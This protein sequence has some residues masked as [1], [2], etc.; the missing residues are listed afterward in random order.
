MNAWSWPALGPSQTD[1]MT[2]RPQA[3]PGLPRRRKGDG[4]PSWPEGR[5]ACRV[6][7]EAVP[8]ESGLS[9]LERG[10]LSPTWHCPLLPRGLWSGQV[11]VTR[12]PSLN[13]G[14]RG[15]H[16]RLSSSFPVLTPHR[17][18]ALSGFTN[19]DTESL[20][21][22][23]LLFAFPMAHLLWEPPSCRAPWDQ[24]I[25]PPLPLPMCIF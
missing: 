10:S 6:V 8:D 16:F 5:G 3:C 1:Q 12:R 20:P 9:V 2:W 13:R 11:S 17:L 14:E 19:Q 22:K 4:K 25:H 23:W 7:T 24:P 21:Q 18:D 15:F